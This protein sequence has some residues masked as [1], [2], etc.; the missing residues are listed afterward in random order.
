[1]KNDNSL[2]ILDLFIICNAL[3]NHISHLPNINLIELCPSSHHLPIPSISSCHHLHLLTIFPS[4]PFNFQKQLQDKAMSDEFKSSVIEQTIVLNS[5]SY[6]ITLIPNIPDKTFVLKIK[7]TTHYLEFRTIKPVSFSFIHPSELQSA[8]KQEHNRSIELNRTMQ[9]MEF[10]YLVRDQ[11]RPLSLTVALECV[12]KE[13]NEELDERL[14][15]L[16]HSMKRVE[17]VCSFIF[18]SIPSACQ[19]HFLSLS[20]CAVSR[21]A[22]RQRS[23]KTRSCESQDS[24]PSS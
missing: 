13:S 9:G 11:Y 19:T 1:M 22:V 24:A 14:T 5:N 7:D 17:K 10:V 2:S 12:K 21:S 3:I 16:E 18:P 15:M 8:L 20:S 4:H 6:H 23:R